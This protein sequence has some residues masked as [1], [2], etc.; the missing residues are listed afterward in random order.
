MT[1][2]T[3]SERLAS[4]IMY[5]E[6]WIDIKPLG[7]VADLGQDAVVERFY[8]PDGDMSRTVFQYTLQE[9]LPGK[10]NETIE[11]ST[12]KVNSHE[13]LAPKSIPEVSPDTNRKVCKSGT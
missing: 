8:R 11:H 3:D 13:G 2:F 7:G 1:D 5:L 4:E 12:S 9:Y 10:V 6:G